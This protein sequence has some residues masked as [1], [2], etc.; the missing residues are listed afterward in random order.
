M[1][2]EH[3]PMEQMDVFRQY[4]AVADWCWNRWDQLARHVTG[5]S[6]P[7]REVSSHR[8]RVPASYRI[9]FGQQRC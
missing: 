1:A 4:V 5:S 8:T 2:S 7:P 9:Y 3:L 6:V